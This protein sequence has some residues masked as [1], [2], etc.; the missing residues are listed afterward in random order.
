MQKERGA[1]WKN[2][3]QLKKYKIR[4]SIWWFLSL[5]ATA[6]YISNKNNIEINIDE[7][8]NERKLRKF[9]KIKKIRR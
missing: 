6:K 3:A 7:N 9:R 4:H 2:S 8:L 5:I 1:F